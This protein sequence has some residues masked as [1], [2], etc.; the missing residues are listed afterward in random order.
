[1]SD[2]VAAKPLPIGPDGLTKRQ[3]S[4]AQPADWVV[5]PACGDRWQRTRRQR[6]HGAV[7]CMKPKRCAWLAAS[8]TR[9]EHFRVGA[10]QRYTGWVRDHA[11]LGRLSPAYQEAVVAL[12][13]EARQ[14]ALRNGGY[15][16]ARRDGRE[17][18]LAHQKRQA[19]A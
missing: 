3:R 2:P 14:E 16:R 4:D 7:H 5:C 17:A 6:R 9:A 10:R 12:A 13:L 15:L 11:V 8:A 19:V 1:M 18:A